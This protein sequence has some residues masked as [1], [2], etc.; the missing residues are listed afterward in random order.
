MAARYAGD[1]F[2]RPLISKEQ[3][4]YMGESELKRRFADLRTMFTPKQKTFQEQ[5]LSTLKAV[6]QQAEKTDESSSSS[7]QQV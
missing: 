2:Y 7:G 5:Y 3:R 6:Q 4:E 1:I